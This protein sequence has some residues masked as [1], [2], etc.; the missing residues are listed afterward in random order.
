MIGAIEGVLKIPKSKNVIN[1]GT[2]DTTGTK[3]NSSKVISSQN[4]YVI[5]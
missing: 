4:D 2:T 5:K 3:W 1:G